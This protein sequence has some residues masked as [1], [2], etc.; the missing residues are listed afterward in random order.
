MED[1]TMSVANPLLHLTDALLLYGSPTPPKDVPLSFGYDAAKGLGEDLPDAMAL[2]TLMRRL[3]ETKLSKP[4]SSMKGP[5]LLRRSWEVLLRAPKGNDA[6][7]KVMDFPLT[8]DGKGAWFIWSEEPVSAA[9]DVRADLR[10]SEPAVQYAER[11]EASSPKALRS[12]GGLSDL[13]VYGAKFIGGLFATRSARQEDLPAAGMALP[14]PKEQL[15]SPEAQ[16][17][18]SEDSLVSYDNVVGLLVALANSGILQKYVDGGRKYAASRGVAI[19]EE[20]LQRLVQS[21]SVLSNRTLVKALTAEVLIKEAL[22]SL[23]L[24]KEKVVQLVRAALT[25]LLGRL[26]LGDKVAALQ[27]MSKVLDEAERW[28]DERGGQPRRPTTD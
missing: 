23:G 4:L 21:F 18:A 5:P 12:S 10:V 19:D 16:S 14:A 27:V 17:P 8:A 20:V 6:L 2:R 11:A 13:L 1:F 7:G 22:V 28:L 3:E 25:D 9:T 15:P 24:P 26:D